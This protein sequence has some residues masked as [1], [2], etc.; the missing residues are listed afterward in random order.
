M[1]DLAGG[2]TDRMARARR[3]RGLRAVVWVPRGLRRGGCV[4][5]YPAF[6]LDSAL[7]DPARPSWLA[8][9]LDDGRVGAIRRPQTLDEIVGSSEDGKSTGRVPNRESC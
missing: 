2:G 6:R 5:T 1:M 7:V 4:G 9:R 8:R 3:P